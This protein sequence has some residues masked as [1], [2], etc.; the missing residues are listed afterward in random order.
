M[1]FLVRRNEPFLMDKNRI[2]RRVIDAAKVENYKKKLELFKHQFPMETLNITVFYGSNPGKRFI[3][4]MQLKFIKWTIK[5][6]K[7]RIENE[8]FFGI[9]HSNFTTLGI[10]LRVDTTGGRPKE[11]VLL[12]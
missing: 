9:K 11:K 12:A 8:T 5:I 7:Y 3:P 4:K 2:I 1:E 10:E 6:T